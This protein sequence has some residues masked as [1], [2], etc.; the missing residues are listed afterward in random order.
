MIAVKI[1]CGCG[2]RYAFDVEPVGHAVPETLRSPSRHERT[3]PRPPD[4]DP[5]LR[6][7]I[8]PIG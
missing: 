5:P 2:Q 1:E 6:Y 4:L 3:A 8:G 7:P